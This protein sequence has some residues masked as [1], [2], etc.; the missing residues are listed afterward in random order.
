LANLRFLFKAIK[1]YTNSPI[2][3]KDSNFSKN[4]SSN[5]ILDQDNIKISNSKGNSIT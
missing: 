2:Y 5:N 3:V 1:P 4:S